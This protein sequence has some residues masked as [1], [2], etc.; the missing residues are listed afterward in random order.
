MRSNLGKVSVSLVN[1][2]NVDGCIYL[3]FWRK[4]AK[5]KFLSMLL[6]TEGL[7]CREFMDKFEKG[8]NFFFLGGGGDRRGLKTMWEQM[9]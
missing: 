3:N 8:V 4:L 2:V 5:L 7:T 6:T 9:L 1:V